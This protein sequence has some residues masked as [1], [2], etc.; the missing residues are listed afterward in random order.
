MEPSS[1]PTEPIPVPEKAPDD[2][3][4]KIMEMVA[5]CEKTE[6]SETPVEQKPHPQIQMIT[7]SRNG[8]QSPTEKSLHY[9]VESALMNDSQ[10]SD[11]GL[12]SDDEETP[13][14]K[15]LRKELGLV[16]EELGVLVKR[17][18][19]DEYVEKRIKEL[20]ERKKWV[21][22]R[23][24]KLIKDRRN[25]AEYRKRKR[26][27]TP[28]VRPR[29]RPRLEEKYP[30]LLAALMDCV[31]NNE[32]SSVPKIKE[33]LSRRHDIDIKKSTLYT[34][35]STT[36]NKT[37]EINEHFMSPLP[38]TS[39]K[40]TPVPSSASSTTSRKEPTVKEYLSQ[41]PQ[42][43][44]PSGENVSANEMIDLFRGLS[45]L[46]AFQVPDEQIQYC[47]DIL[48]PFFTKNDPAS[49]PILGQLAEN[50][51]KI[52]N[53]NIHRTRQVFDTS[54]SNQII[55]VSDEQNQ[56]ADHDGNI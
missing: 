36:P 48:R 7:R 11:E 10:G 49:L 12:L 4:Q 40:R 45:Q 35:I 5:S 50:A 26:A 16:E 55:I 18:E 19:R 20:V 15:E 43:R 30:Q 21:D 25:Q 44:Q 54:D 9:L 13:K 32:T 14:V 47:F 1:E 6:T 29:G 34:R 51:Q 53:A 46:A 3:F 2:N 24:T 52:F 41:P 28:K 37:K 38:Q 56:W 27:R 33:E 17:V 31:D 39:S 22:M 23:I 8:I 42:Q